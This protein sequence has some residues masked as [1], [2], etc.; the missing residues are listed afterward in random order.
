[1]C[2]N[3]PFPDPGSSMLIK[4][5]LWQQMLGRNSNKEANVFH[6]YVF[7]F[8]WQV[9]V[10]YVF[11]V[12]V[13]PCKRTHPKVIYVVIN[14]LGLIRIWHHVILNEIT[15]SGKFASIS[16]FESFMWYMFRSMKNQELSQMAPIRADQCRAPP[17]TS[18]TAIISWIH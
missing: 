2:P 7:L 11:D 17:A 12:C 13:S 1:M 15:F 16:F 5:R 8:A 10:V 6:V 4:G 3:D 14:D 18:H 9:R